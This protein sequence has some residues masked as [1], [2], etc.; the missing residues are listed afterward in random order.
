MPQDLSA[1]PLDIL[2]EICENLSLGDLARFALT[3]K[4]FA[5]VGTPRLYDQ[6]FFHRIARKHNIAKLKSDFVLN[7]VAANSSKLLRYRAPN[8]RS[9]LH[10]IAAAGNEVLLAVFLKL[11]AN[12]SVRCDQGE[13]ALHVA[14]E[15]GQDAI[16]VQLLEAG[17]DVLTPACRRP[18]LAFLHNDLSRSTAE[19]AIRAILAAGGDISACGPGG[20]TALHYASRSG[21]DHIVKVLLEKGADALATNKY[22]HIPLVSAVLHRRVEVSR[23]LLDAMTRDPRGYDLN[24]PLASLKDIPSS[25]V[26]EGRG[27]YFETGYTLL[28]CAV[29]I[30]HAPTVQLLLDFGA[31]PLAESNPLSR[32]GR[33]PFDIAV[34]GRCPELV[35]LIAGMKNPPVFWKSNGYIQ[36]GFETCVHESYPGT[37]RTLVDLYKQGKVDLDIAAATPRMLSACTYYGSHVMDK[38]VN[39]S[40]ISCL[41]AGVDVN[42]QDEDGKTALHLLCEPGDSEH[43]E[44]KIR[45]I[46][47]FLSR[48]ADWTIRDK[49]GNTALHAAADNGDFE[50]DAVVRHIIQVATERR[51]TEI[52]ASPNNFG[53]TPLHLY[54]AGAETTGQRNQKIIKLL[55]DN[56]CDVNVADSVNRQ[57]PAADQ[58]C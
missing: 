40:I 5:A 19:K 37:V 47:Y 12:I 56:G 36:S 24:A 49:H 50:Y 38:D 20:H 26:P 34:M 22:G 46:E 23:I 28:H 21:H 17:A 8:G 27:Y 30:F 35:V 57:L 29:S 41:S 51:K 39:D 32:P 11:G 33:T 42:A 3:S 7:Y 2:L 14:L 4:F 15:K 13:T 18:T 9:V 10:Y 52:L 25:W 31:D 48:G 55:L 45:L 43:N 54:L 53:K 1:I 44:A 6:L 58:C 16:A